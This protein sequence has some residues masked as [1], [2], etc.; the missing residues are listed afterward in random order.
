MNGKK[1]WSE[2][3]V[4]RVKNVETM[5][6]KEI[7]STIREFL[8]NDEQNED[9]KNTEQSDESKFGGKKLSSEREVQKRSEA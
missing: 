2:R 3:E 8:N 9:R 1:F 5:S 4:Q 7:Q 6:S